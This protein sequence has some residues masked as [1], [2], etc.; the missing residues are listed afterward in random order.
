MAYEQDGSG[1]A[2]A[3]ERT[4]ADLNRQGTLLANLN[5]PEV[6]CEG[7]GTMTSFGPKLCR[8]CSAAAEARLAERQAASDAACKAARDENRRAWAASE[9]MTLEELCLREGFDPPI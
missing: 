5:K 4:A 7:C 9:G 2:P 1:P 3:A 8:D 6:A